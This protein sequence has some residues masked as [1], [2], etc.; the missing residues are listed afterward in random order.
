MLL[1]AVTIT[2]KRFLEVVQLQLTLQ[3][4]VKG[5]YAASIM[6][7]YQ[8]LLI[9][10]L[11]LVS[12]ICFLIYK[13][14]YDR[15]RNV[16]EVLEV[17]GSPPPPNPAAALQSQQHPLDTNLNPALGAGSINELNLGQGNYD[18]AHH[19][20]KLV[21]DTFV[22][23]NGHG[24][25]PPDN[26]EPGP[27]DGNNLDKKHN[28]IQNPIQNSGEVMDEGG[29]VAGADDGVA[30]KFGALKA[31]KPMPRQLQASI[32]KESHRKAAEDV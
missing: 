16:L 14:E 19:L 12:F 27:G 18:N 24:V 6:K 1:T 4:Q 7:K 5:S 15:L 32:F 21:D 22:L 20:D 10:S 30:G 26:D 17:F 2:C 11:G 8:Q 31:K 13:H 9:V 23:K 28:V 25:R 3:V 29:G